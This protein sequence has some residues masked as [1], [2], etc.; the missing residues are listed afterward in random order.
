MG[1]ELFH[2]LGGE[3]TVLGPRNGSFRSR[4]E[5]FGGPLLATSLGEQ[6]WLQSWL[7]R[8]THLAVGQIWG[9]CTT[10]FSRLFLHLD[11]HWGHGLWILTRGHFL[12]LRLWMDIHFAPEGFHQARP[13][14]SCFCQR[15]AQDKHKI[16]PS[17]ASPLFSV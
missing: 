9:R 17:W 16:R 13:V 6:G 3:L 14:R 7:Q 2:D 11:V 10:L 8:Y 15:T 5:G 4:A 12:I 1:S